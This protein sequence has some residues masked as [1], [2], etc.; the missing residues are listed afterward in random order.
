MQTRVKARF[1]SIAEA[2][3]EGQTVRVLCCGAT[4]ACKVSCSNYGYHEFCFRCGWKHFTPHRARSLKQILES[5]ALRSQTI[6]TTTVAELP[7]DY[8]SEVPME[9]SLWCMKYGVTPDIMQVYG[10]GWSEELQRVVLPTYSRE[11]ELTCVQMR[12]VHPDQQPKY[13]NLGSDPATLFW[14][15]PLPERAVVVT[16]D[17]MSA[18]KVA[19]VHPAVSTLGTNCND[20][21]ALEIARACSTAIIWY[22]SDAA[23]TNGAAKAARML[24]FCGVQTINICTPKDPKEYS[25]QE[26]TNILKDAAC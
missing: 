6:Q 12:A 18:I 20:G 19:R 9:G 26:I 24:G 10:I 16:E 15:R 25:S 7:A 11:G 14:T 1:G 4:P 3:Q 5:R 23:G 2:L 8:T 13:L 17:I 21:K 22:D